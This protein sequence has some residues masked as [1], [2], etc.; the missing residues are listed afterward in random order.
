M[1]LGPDIDGMTEKVAAE[2]R[3]PDRDI[4]I[5]LQNRIWRVVRAASS[6]KSMHRYYFDQV[7]RKITERSAT[8]RTARARIG[9][10]I[11]S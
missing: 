4:T 6:E 8:A 11:A 9:T 10:R 7:H 1:G 5:T 2:L 3:N